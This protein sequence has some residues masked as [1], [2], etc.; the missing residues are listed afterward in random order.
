LCEWKGYL[1]HLG[2]PNAFLSVKESWKWQQIVVLMWPQRST[3][4][5]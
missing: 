1:R 2:E 5:S 4:W 3:A